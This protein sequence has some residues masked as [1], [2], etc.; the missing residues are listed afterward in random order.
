MINLECST[1]VGRNVIQEPRR[2]KF[3]LLKYYEKY[4]DNPFIATAE[5]IAKGYAISKVDGPLPIMDVIGITY[6]VFDAGS[7]WYGYFTD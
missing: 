6:A 7:A 3:Q 2:S 4:A 1:M 5:A